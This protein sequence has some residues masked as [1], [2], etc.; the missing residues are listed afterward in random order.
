M[1]IQPSLLP[2]LPR[3]RS[4][5]G[6]WYQAPDGKR[7]IDLSAQTLNLPFGQPPREVRDAVVATIENGNVFFSSR[8]GSDEFEELGNRLV[9]L[10]PENI[11]TV[12][13]KLC[14]GTDAV[15]TALKIAYHNQRTK[16]TLVLRDAWH[17]ES[18]ATLSLS[19]S[20]RSK[21][22]ALG[23]EDIALAKNNDISSL[24]ELAKETTRPSTVIV[25]PIGFSRGL[26]DPNSLK[27]CLLQL[28]EE[29]SKNGHI[30]IFDE[31]QCFGGFLGHGFFSADLF[32]VEADIITIGK[33]LGQ[34]FPVAA[35]LYSGVLSDL[36]YNEAEFTYGG[37][38]PACSAALAGLKYVEKNRADINAS[39][40]KWGSVVSLLKSEFGDLSVRNI[41]FFCVV[42]FKDTEKAS[43]VF[44]HLVDNGVFSRRI[45]AGSS[46]AFKCPLNFD[47]EGAQHVKIAL[48]SCSH[49]QSA[50]TPD[51]LVSV[52]EKENTNERYAKAVLSKFSDLRLASRSPHEQAKL[53]AVLKK[54]HIP[55]PLLEAKDDNSASYQYVVGVSLDDFVA[56][57]A[58]EAKTIYCLLVDWI[59]KAHE[60]HIVLGDRWPGNTIWNGE[61]LTFIDFDLCYEGTFQRAASFEHFFAIFHHAN[62]I[63]Q[64]TDFTEFIRPFIL[65]YMDIWGTQ[66][67]LGVIDQ[68]CE[69]YS[70]PRKP[71]N[72]GS[73][74]IQSYQKL[75]KAIKASVT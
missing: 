14:N 75:I 60:N 21:H 15:E 43:S 35:C 2:V 9:E 1:T 26:F 47:D 10:S 59:K 44:A 3:L 31:I 27:S 25:D 55:C 48:S 19:S 40:E 49:L 53:T 23:Y 70:N 6:P 66:G 34:G 32:S 73:L 39:S 42:D 67:A 4:I 17:G 71:K 46:L 50:R 20:L 68:F 13:H 54:I 63:P 38:P 7:C 41:G 16:Q 11:T 45:M 8:F 62:I 56:Q 33:A 58:K 24:V 37:Q 28:R 52:L 5:E 29:C 69:F 57:S 18:F 64:D 61:A 74:D 65:E 12:N 30:L 72:E 36:Q 51:N 22:L